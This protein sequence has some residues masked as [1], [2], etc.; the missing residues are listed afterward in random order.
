[1]C[2]LCVWKGLGNWLIRQR[3]HRKK[4]KLT[5]ERE[6]KLQQLVDQGKFVWDIQEAFD[7]SWED[8]FKQLQEYGEQHGHCNVPRSTA[9][10]K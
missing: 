1:M 10:K 6:A 2:V 9:G 4:G 7:S 5:A 8:N 3:E